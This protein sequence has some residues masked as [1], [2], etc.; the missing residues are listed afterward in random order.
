[1]SHTTTRITKKERSNALYQAILRLETEEEC[2]SFF[3]DLCTISELCSMEQ[4]FEVAKLLRQGC[5]YTEI[6]EKTGASS[7]TITRVNRCLNY[8]AEGYRRV[9]EKLEE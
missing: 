5:I 1:M 2:R 4:R 7:A 3:E 6:M 8:G 9:L